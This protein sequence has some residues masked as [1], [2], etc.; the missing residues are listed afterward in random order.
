MEK[1][2]SPPPNRTDNWVERAHLCVAAGQKDGREVPQAAY[3]R[4]HWIPN[5]HGAQLIAERAWPAHLVPRLALQRAPAHVVDRQRPQP[6][7]RSGQRLLRHAYGDIGERVGKDD[8]STQACS[9]NVCIKLSHFESFKVQAAPS[10]C[11][12]HITPPSA[13]PLDLPPPRTCSGISTQ[14][15]KSAPAVSRRWSSSSSSPPPLRT[16]TPL[17]SA[18]LLAIRPG[19]RPLTARGGGEAS[20]GDCSQLCMERSAWQREKRKEHTQQ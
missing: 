2:P 5:A 1:V 12:S 10:T 7:A 8:A 4:G 14:P 19:L 18:R 16:V 3:S 17:R 13:P 6:S 15:M 11:L 20:A 9:Q